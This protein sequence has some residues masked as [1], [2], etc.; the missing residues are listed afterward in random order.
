MNYKKGENNMSVLIYYD[1]YSVMSFY[2]GW[3]GFSPVV[4]NMFEETFP[5]FV[6]IL[7]EQV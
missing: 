5:S 4:L 6:V 3:F 1:N 7:K 2:V